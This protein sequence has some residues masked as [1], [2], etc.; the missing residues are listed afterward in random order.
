MGVDTSPTPYEF[1]SAINTGLFNPESV[2][3]PVSCATGNCTFGLYHTIAYCSKCTD[4]SSLLNSNDTYTERNFTFPE[5]SSNTNLTDRL[6]VSVTDDLIEYLKLRTTSSDN[7]TTEVIAASFE[8][9]YMGTGNNCTT[10]AAKTTWGCIGYGAA[11]CSLYPC[12]RSYVAAVVESKLQET[13]LATSAEFGTDNYDSVRTSVEV[14]CLT[15]KMRQN[16]ISLEYNITEA[17]KWIDYRGPYHFANGSGVSSPNI[18]DDPLPAECQYWVKSSVETTVGVFLESFLNGTVSAS[19]LI[20]NQPNGSVQ[21]NKLFN[22]G[23]LSFESID[24][25]FSN[26]SDSMTA[27]I[28]Q[29]PPQS[30]MQLDETPASARGRAFQTQTCIQV[31]WGYLTVFVALVLLTTTFL[32]AV[33]RETSRHHEA[34]PWKSSSLALLFHGLHPETRDPHGGEMA[35]VE[36]METVAKEMRVRLRKGRKGWVFVE[37]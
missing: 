3:I 2:N 37:G 9:L 26:I 8:K 10:A 13:L 12:V 15:Q 25:I 14:A 18:T 33:M 34:D 20:S 32:V 1:Q 28:R 21:L 6:S 36:E 27:Y 19:P 17:T 30:G 24:A 31:R 29:I 16:L 23:R 7:V 11:S 22:D 4:L 35:S 5:T